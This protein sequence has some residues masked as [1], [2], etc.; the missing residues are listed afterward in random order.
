MVSLVMVVRDILVD[1]ASHVAL[2]EWNQ[3]MQA[4]E[5]DGAHEPFTVSVEMQTPWRQDERLH[6]ARTQHLV[7]V[8]SK[9]R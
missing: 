8:M 6:S 1:R 4:F 9:F 3:S 5:L 7:E 2:A